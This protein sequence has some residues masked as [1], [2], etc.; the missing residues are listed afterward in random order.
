MNFESKYSTSHTN[1]RA[2]RAAVTDRQ[3]VKPDAFRYFSVAAGRADP[4]LM[5]K[6]TVNLSSSKYF[7]ASAHK[8]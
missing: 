1:L 8:S 5:K 4:S 6:A 2:E 3:N 7:D